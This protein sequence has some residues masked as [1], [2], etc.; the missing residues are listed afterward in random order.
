[1]KRV[2]ILLIATLALA[3]CGGPAQK[4][5]L[6][7]SL[8]AKDIA[9][10]T[11]AIEVAA[12]QPVKLL[13][14]KTGALEHDFSIL[15]IPLANKVEQGEAAGGHNMNMG[16]DPQLHVAAAPGKSAIIKFTATKPGTYEFYCTTAGHKEAGM[17]GTLV[18]KE[19]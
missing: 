14:K 19:P 18:I 16:V 6:E 9:F 7:I 3:A 11:T 4:T 8:D 10:G 12:G 17:I 1:M 13:L 5:T 2:F 15:E